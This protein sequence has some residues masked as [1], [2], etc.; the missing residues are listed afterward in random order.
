MKTTLKS[1]LFAALAFALASTSF[2]APARADSREVAKVVAG[3]TALYIIGKA[4]NDSQ[5]HARPT[6]ILVPPVDHHHRR[7]EPPRIVTKVIPAACYTELYRT[8]GSIAKGYGAKC[9]KNRVS[10][11]HLLPTQCIRAEQTTRG[12]RALYPSICLARN[13]WVGQNV[14]GVRH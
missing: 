12:K 11:P 13:G 8:N 2:A 3:L 4:L 5:A 6:P 14:R 1:T 9:M 7:P 10:Q